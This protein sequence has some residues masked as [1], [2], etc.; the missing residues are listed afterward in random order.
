MHKPHRP[1]ARKG[2]MLIRLLIEHEPLTSESVRYLPEAPKTDVKQ[3]R[4]VTASVHEPTEWVIAEGA[5]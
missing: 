2:T 3:S 1:D 5:R 4:S